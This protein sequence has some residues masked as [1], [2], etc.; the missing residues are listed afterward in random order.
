M[1]VAVLPTFAGAVHAF[2]YYFLFE[3]AP[4]VDR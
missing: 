4:K 1:L 3:F 2:F